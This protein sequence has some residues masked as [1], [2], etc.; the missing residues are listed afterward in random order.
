MPARGRPYAQCPSA[1]APLA[2]PWRKA[3]LQLLQQRSDLA[4]RGAAQEAEAVLELDLEAGGV[5]GHLVRQGRLSEAVH[6]MLRHLPVKVVRAGDVVEPYAPAVV[7]ALQRLARGHPRSV[8]PMFVPQ[9]PRQKG[10]R[11]PRVWEDVKL[12]VEEAGLLTSVRVEGPGQEV[13]AAQRPREE[14][15]RDPELRVQLRVVDLD[16]RGRRREEAELGEA[17][18]SVLLRIGAPPRRV[19]GHPG[20]EDI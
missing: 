4:V 18:A 3:A 12:R 8:V 13:P 1:G 7:H 15:R 9:R 19:H 5:Y 6:V 14:L 20:A 11:R 2:G 17:A 16:E 10:R